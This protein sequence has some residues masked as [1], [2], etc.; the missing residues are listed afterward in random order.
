[1]MLL[2]M[3]VMIPL[4]LIWF[5]FLNHLVEPFTTTITVLWYRFSLVD[6][7]EKALYRLTKDLDEEYVL[8]KNV[9]D[10]RLRIGLT[11]TSKWFQSIPMTRRQQSNN[12]AS[13]RNNTS[14]AYVYVDEYTSIP[15]IIAACVLSSYIPGLTGPSLIWER[16]NMTH[17]AVSRSQ[18][19]VQQ[20]VERNASKKKAGNPIQK[21]DPMILER[22]IPTTTCSR[23]FWDGG[24]T[25]VFPLVNNDTLLVTPFEGRFYNPTITP[26]CN[27]YHQHQKQ[28]QRTST[29][30]TI[31]PTHDQLTGSAGRLVGNHS[32]WSLLFPGSEANHIDSGF[33][34]PQLDMSFSNVRA[35]RYIALSSSDTELESWFLQGYDNAANYLNQQGALSK[36]TVAVP[37]V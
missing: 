36:F 1:M 27:Y 16:S 15:E 4:V 19:I 30:A 13:N 37:S 8:R 20:M 12:R 23:Q 34:T 14:S 11:D 29:R 5:S 2:L 6:Q 31:E 25:N 17:P 3:T 32:P 9:P 21:T 24:L 18:R 33:V 28:Q 7:V 10:G 26:S 35:M 22:K